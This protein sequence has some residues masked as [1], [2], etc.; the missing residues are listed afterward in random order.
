[1]VNYVAQS[2]LFVFRSPENMPRESLRGN[3]EEREKYF[4]QYSFA[5]PDPQALQVIKKYSP[6][7]ELGAGTGYWAKLLNEIGC[8]V[9][10]YDKHITGNHYFKEK[11]GYHYSVMEGDESVLDSY[12]EEYNLFLCW[13]DYDCEWAFNALKCFKGQYVIYIGEGYGGCT[14]DDDFHEELERY[15]ERVEEHDLKQW[16][17]IHDEL[18]VYKRKTNY[19]EV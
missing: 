2:D 5:L 19:L 6:I 14:A 8:L 17:A 16:W 13:P 11:V 12:T 1:M 7:I 3:F 18:T 10:A 4:R 9:L 15:W